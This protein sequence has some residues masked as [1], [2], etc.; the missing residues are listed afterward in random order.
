[1]TKI[2]RVIPAS[3]RTIASS[4]AYTQMRCA[5]GSIARATGT[6]PWPYA[7]DFTTNAAL[8][9]AIRSRSACALLRSASSEMRTLPVIDECYGD[10]E[11]NGMRANRNRD[12]SAAVDNQ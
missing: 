4:N 3:R 5:K 8:A 7:F 1:M 11:E 6:R 2:G 9:G 10:A 12:L